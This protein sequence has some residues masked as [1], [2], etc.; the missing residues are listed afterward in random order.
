MICRK[1]LDLVASPLPPFQPFCYILNEVYG[2]PLVPP[3][4][5]L[6]RAFDASQTLRSLS[7]L[8]RSSLCCHLVHLN[9]S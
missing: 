4:R 6:R 1:P 8:N 9:R 3:T 2:K 7:P 5:P